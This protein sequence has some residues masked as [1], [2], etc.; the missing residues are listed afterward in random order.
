M[1]FVPLNVTVLET[2]NLEFIPIKRLVLF[3]SLVKVHQKCN[4]QLFTVVGRSDSS[5]NEILSTNIRSVSV[6][7]H[8]PFP[9]CIP[10]VL[11]HQIKSRLL[12]VIYCCECKHGIYFVH[13]SAI[14][15]K[16]FFVARI[17]LSVHCHRRR[18]G[19]ESV[20][21]IYRYCFFVSVASD[22]PFGHSLDAYLSITIRIFF[23]CEFNLNLIFFSVLCFPRLSFS[24][25]PFHS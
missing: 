9:H 20:R 6:S 21:Y 19:R 10:C 7:C 17:N 5:Y 11:V 14:H 2:L 24:L 4:C 18:S 1:L 12:A 16:H 15:L 13:Q 8:C 25:Q 22:V 23:R 3:Q